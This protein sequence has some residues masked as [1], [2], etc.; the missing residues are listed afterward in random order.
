APL[1]FRQRPVAALDDEPRLHRG[2]LALQR[3]RVEAFADLAFD[4]LMRVLDGPAEAGHYRRIADDPAEAG[5][6]RRIAAGPV[7]AG[8]YRRIAARMVRP[9]AAGNPVAGIPVAGIP[10]VSGFSR[11]SPGDRALHLAHRIPRL[12]EAPLLQILVVQPRQR[13]E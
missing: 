12:R 13:V 3:H 11:T 1:P 7:E 2:K 4:M 6:Y 10:V 5:H 8:P 9:A